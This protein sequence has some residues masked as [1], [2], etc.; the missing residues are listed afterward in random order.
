MIYEL[1]ILTQS[2]RFTCSRL[3]LAK[4]FELDKLIEDLRCNLFKL[5]SNEFLKSS[6]WRELRSLLAAVLG[7][8]VWKGRA[9][10]VII[11]FFPVRRLEVLFISELFISLLRLRNY[12]FFLRIFSI[13]FSLKGSFLLLGLS[14][15]FFFL[16]LDRFIGCSSSFFAYSLTLS[17][18]FRSLCNRG[19]LVRVGR[20]DQLSDRYNVF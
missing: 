9:F 17:L 3:W 20:I 5:F 6:S 1:E 13:L 18:F 4:F 10:F 19:N 7:L 8:I 14:F 2:W 15:L 11:N 16:G 12:F